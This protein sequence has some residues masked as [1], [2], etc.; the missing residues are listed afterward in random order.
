MGIKTIPRHPRIPQRRDAPL[1]LKFG[2]VKHL[3]KPKPLTFLYLEMDWFVHMHTHAYPILK[4][5]C[6][7]IQYNRVFSLTTSWRETD[8]F[9]S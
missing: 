8:N 6:E 5:N 1:V 3:R 7:N 9:S 2:A 4:I